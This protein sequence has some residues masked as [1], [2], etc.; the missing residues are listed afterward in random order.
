MVS[1]YE[2]GHRKPA[3]ETLQRLLGATGHRVDIDLVADTTSPVLAGE[4]GRRVRR[5]RDEIVNIAAAHG[6]RNV[7]IFGS[8]ARGDEHS[9]SDV[10]VLVDLEPS[11]GLFTL[12]RLERDLTEF[13]GVGVDVIPSDSL[14]PDVRAAAEHDVVSL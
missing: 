8:V 9:S 3:F 4:L 2:A 13:L 12:M 10:D 6:A 5:H 7:R 1:A 11:T 14:K